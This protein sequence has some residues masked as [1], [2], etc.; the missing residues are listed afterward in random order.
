MTSLLITDLSLD[1][2]GELSEALSQGPDREELTDTDQELSAEQ[3]YRGTLCGV[4]SF[5]GWDQVPEFDLSSSAQD[6]N[7]FAGA[8]SQLPGKVSVKV[9]VDDWLC[10]KF[11]KLNIT[12]QEGYPSRASETAG[13]V[14]DQFVK[15][16]RTLKWYDMYTE[17]KDF[18]RSKVFSWTNQ[19]PRLNSSFPCIANRSL[20]SAP[21]LSR[22]TH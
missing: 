9:P 11:E 1:E 10:R 16:P 22:R 21:D 20:P 7:P 8:R 19:A 2:E 3:T 12:V 4:R 13:L 15:P 14:R 18:S 6:D 17:K 5:M